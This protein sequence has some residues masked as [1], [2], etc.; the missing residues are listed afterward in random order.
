[1]IWCQKRKR[2]LIRMLSLK[3][4]AI[5]NHRTG[6]RC[7]NYSCFSRPRSIIYHFTVI[8][9]LVLFWL[10]HHT[11][12]SL[13]D[14]LI[15]LDKVYFPLG[16]SL[17]LFGKQVEFSDPS[18]QEWSLNPSIYF[19]PPLAEH[20]NFIENDR[21]RRIKT[22]ATYLRVSLNEVNIFSVLEIALLTFFK[23]VLFITFCWYFMNNSRLKWC[24]VSF[25]LSFVLNCINNLI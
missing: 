11:H 9:V 1:M 18:C 8:S 10:I 15:N 16:K 6:T 17:T 25:W 5:I 2:I 24:H 19:H 13:W 20:S 3:M 7:G 12:R 23:S 14:L 21:R 4:E 22:M